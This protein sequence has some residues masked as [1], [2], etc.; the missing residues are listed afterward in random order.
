MRWFESAGI[1]AIILFIVLMIVGIVF[2]IITAITI[3]DALHVIG[4]KWW[5]VALT[6]FGTIS[7][8]LITIKRD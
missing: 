7:S 8:P 3:T 5:I 2:S 1:F 4:W 6:L